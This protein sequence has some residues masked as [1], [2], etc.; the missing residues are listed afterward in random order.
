MVSQQKWYFTARNCFKVAAE[1]RTEGNPQLSGQE[2]H[3]MIGV[4]AVIPNVYAMEG[5]TNQSENK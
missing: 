2:K 4:M 1:M 3:A 5:N